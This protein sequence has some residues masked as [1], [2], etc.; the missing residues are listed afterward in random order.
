M[1]RRN[2]TLIE[3]LVVIAI[4]AILASMLLP[5]L[6]RARATAQSISCVG[7]LKQIGLAEAF[8]QGDFDD[9]MMPV[10][11]NDSVTGYGTSPYFPIVLVDMYGMTGKSLQCP[12]AG[13]APAARLCKGATGLKDYDLGSLGYGMNSDCIGMTTKSTEPCVQKISG[14]PGKGYS[15]QTVVLAD[16]ITA[17]PEQEYPIYCILIW[18]SHGIFPL[19]TRADICQASAERHNNR[20][21]TL[22]LDGHAQ[23]NT[24]QELARNQDN[25]GMEMKNKYWWPKVNGDPVNVPYWW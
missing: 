10:V 9:Y 16:S 6:S 7:N 11:L 8:Y 1:K 4:I 18:T 22:H 23:N 25:A 3:L 20:A 12:S 15:S 5:A 14:M 13:D 24:A 2:F 17:V 21:N 19:A